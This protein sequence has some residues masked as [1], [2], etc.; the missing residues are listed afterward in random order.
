MP[1]WVLITAHTA[2]YTVQHS[3][4]EY[5]CHPTTHPYVHTHT[6]THTH[7]LTHKVTFT[8]W[9]A[10]PAVATWFEELEVLSAAR[11]LQVQKFHTE[12]A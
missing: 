1:P 11:S 6:H 7:T 4:H 12:L 10:M 9:A 3:S 5:A 2:F 8:A